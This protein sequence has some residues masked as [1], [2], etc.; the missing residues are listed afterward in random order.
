MPQSEG[1]GSRPPANGGGE[2]VPAADGGEVRVG[3]PIRQ[4]LMAPRPGLTAHAAGVRP[5]AAGLLNA[6]VDS[7][8]LD[9]VKRIKRPRRT[10][11][12]FGA[13]SGEATDRARGRFG[14]RRRKPFCSSVFS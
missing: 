12:T 13:S 4:Y 8:G 5:M 6:T 10:L 1:R 7:M 3:P 2:Q 9:V 14:S 11:A